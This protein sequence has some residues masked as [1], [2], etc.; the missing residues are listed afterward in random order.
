M[1]DPA[2]T[3]Q[4]MPHM[5]MLTRRISPGL[6]GAASGVSSPIVVMEVR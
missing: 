6:Y 5:S 4:Q 1:R 2:G 3:I